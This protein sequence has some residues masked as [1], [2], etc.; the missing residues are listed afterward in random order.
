VLWAVGGG[1]HEDLAASL[2][3]VEQNQQLSH[4][5][6]LVLGAFGGAGGRNGV[7]LVEDND[8]R[9]EL[10]SALEDVSERLGASVPRTSCRR[11][12]PPAS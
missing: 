10:L 2:D 11:P 5:G 8:G 6:D 4:H 9:G 12:P 1:E 3:A 7:Y